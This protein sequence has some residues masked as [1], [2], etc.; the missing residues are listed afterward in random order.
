MDA[1]RTIVMIN[2]FSKSGIVGIIALVFCV[3]GIG[4]GVLMV[5]S[6]I[7]LIRY[8]KRSGLK[9]KALMEGAQIATEYAKE[10]QDEVQRITASNGK[11]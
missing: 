9:A 3:I 6:C 1:I 10:N 11:T 4:I 5:L 8:Y 2:A 7:W